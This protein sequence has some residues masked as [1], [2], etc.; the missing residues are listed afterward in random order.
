MGRRKNYP[1]DSRVDKQMTSLISGLITGIISVPFLLFSPSK[2]EFYHDPEDGGCMLPLFI[3]VGILIFPFIKLTVPI[4]NALSYFDSIIVSFILLILSYWLIFG[5]EIYLLYILSKFIDKFENKY[6]CLINFIVFRSYKSR[7]RKIRKDY[8]NTVRKN[9][10]AKSKVKELYN[11]IKHYQNLLDENVGTEKEQ[12]YRDIIEHSQQELY[13]IK[14]NIFNVFRTDYKE[15]VIQLPCNQKDT[16][17]NFDGYVY[18][19]IDKKFTVRKT[20]KIE[21]ILPLSNNGT[22][23]FKTNIKPLKSLFNESITIHFYDRYTL[24][25]TKKNFTIVG[26]EN[27]IG[28]YIKTS[29]EFCLGCKGNSEVIETDRLDCLP[30]FRKDNTNEFVMT[31]VGKLQLNFFSRKMHFLFTKY[32]EGKA[33]YEL[34]KMTNKETK[35]L[36]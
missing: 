26:Y 22:M 7:Y 18:L 20:I 4:W 31:D 21:E 30:E 17:P 15:P 16:Q 28:S 12:R 13:K 10:R 6:E 8:F 25:M 35:Q 9:K 36:S 14:K 3:F 11:K 33:I 2:N 1:F 27:V 34:I 32:D 29:V 24:L 23:F 5:I 19:S